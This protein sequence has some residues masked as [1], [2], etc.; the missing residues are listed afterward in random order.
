[1][2]NCKSNFFLIGL[3]P[4]YQI[5][6]LN[7]RCRESPH[8]RNSAQEDSEENKRQ[9][10]HRLKKDFVTNCARGTGLTAEHSAANKRPG[11]TKKLY[12]MDVLTSD[13]RGSHYCKMQLGTLAKCR[14]KEQS[15]AYLRIWGTCLR[16][17]LRRYKAPLFLIV[18]FDV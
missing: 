8:N 10:P 4:S 1:M 13:W 9:D 5:K 11:P 14:G 2:P 7:H 18:L 6:V 16:R 15:L 17:R 3:T 12:K